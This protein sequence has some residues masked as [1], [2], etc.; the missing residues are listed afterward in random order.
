MLTI[1]LLIAAANVKNSCIFLVLPLLFFQ[2]TPHGHN[3]HGHNPH[4]HNP[5]GHSPI[6]MVL[7][8]PIPRMPV[9]APVPAPA[10]APKDTGLDLSGLDLS[11]IGSSIGAS[12]TANSAKE[13]GADDTSSKTAETT[14][15]P[16]AVKGLV[17][18]LSGAGDSSSG[19]D[20]A[21]EGVS[22]DDAKNFLRPLPDE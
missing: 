14:I 11:G 15:D 20:D 19:G 22:L 7:K 2:H 9:P 10:P 12:M 21:E 6:M 8:A 4:G 16:V 5:H 3:P 17:G 1:F 13:D 18:A